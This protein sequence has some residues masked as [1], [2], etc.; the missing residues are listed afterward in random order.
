MLIFFVPRPTHLLL[1]LDVALLPFELFL[2]TLV[3]FLQAFDRV[4]EGTEL[5]GG[6]AL[7]VRD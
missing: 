7:L 3:L 2:L 1:V 4:R 6:D 5:I